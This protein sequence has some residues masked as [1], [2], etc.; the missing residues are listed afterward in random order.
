MPGEII[1]KQLDDMILLRAAKEYLDLRIQ[2]LLSKD[3]REEALRSVILMMQLARQI[4]RKPFIVNFL[5]NMAITN[6]ATKCANNA[7][8][9]G[10]VS[11]QTRAALDAELSLHGSM[12]I[13]R[14]AMKSDR[15]LSLDF[16][17][18]IL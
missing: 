15:A 8:Q 6:N 17:E 1:A 16:L 10:P 5:V 2:V 7:L 9:A 14:T 18:K 13:F 11:E 12:D 4:E 3:K